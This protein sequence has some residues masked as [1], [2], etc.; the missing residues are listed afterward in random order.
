MGPNALNLLLEPGRISERG[1][2]RANLLSGW[3]DCH[4][5]LPCTW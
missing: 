5:V 1:C 2:S 4:G 3:F